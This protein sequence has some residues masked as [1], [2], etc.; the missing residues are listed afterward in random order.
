M[1]QMHIAAQEFALQR[2]NDL[3]PFA[4]RPLY[5]KIASELDRVAQGLGV[6]V[7]AEL[8]FLAEHATLNIPQGVIHADLFTDNVFFKDGTLSGIIDF[9]FACNDFLAYDL[10]V[11]VNDWCF[12]ENVMDIRKTRALLEG[13]ETV[14]PLDR[15]EKDALPLLCR[16]AALRFMMTRAHDWI[17][18]VEGALVQVKDPKEY[19]TKWEFHRQ[20]SQDHVYGI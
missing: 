6:S 20:N 18:Q 2:S 5:T 8:A 19:L 17:Y 15:A 3:S 1:A 16:G 11:V 13:Y 10:A 7:E 14:R 9:Y 12:A 4:L